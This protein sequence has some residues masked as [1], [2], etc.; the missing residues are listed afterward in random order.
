MATGMVLMVPLIVAAILSLWMGSFFHLSQL[1]DIRCPV[2]KT[3]FD[4]I[5]RLRRHLKQGAHIRR[6]ETRKAA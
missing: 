1:A 4:D 6:D 3:P 2:C 5:F